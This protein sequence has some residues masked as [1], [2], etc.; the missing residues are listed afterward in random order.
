MGASSITSDSA[1]RNSIANGLQQ[2][3]RSASNDKGG[4]S[5][6]LAGVNVSSLAVSEGPDVAVSLKVDWFGPVSGEESCNVPH[7]NPTNRTRPRAPEIPIMW[8][9]MLV[10]R[11]PRLYLN[12]KLFPPSHLLR[13]STG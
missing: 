4:V 2:N 10:R 9:E 6:I 5:S 8:R 11:G 13:A 12:C 7:P 3:H 1:T